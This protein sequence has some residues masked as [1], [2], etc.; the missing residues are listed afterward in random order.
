ML[1]SSYLDVSDTLSCP[2]HAQVLHS[3]EKL[4]IISPSELTPVL[5]DSN[6]SP[7]SNNLSLVPNLDLGK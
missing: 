3:A 7:T 1:L 4:G 2:S 5:P 6:Q